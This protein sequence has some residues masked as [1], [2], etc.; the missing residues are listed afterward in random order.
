MS[1]EYIA[2][3]ATPWSLTV[4]YKT[5]LQ[6]SRTTPERFRMSRRALPDSVFPSC[7]QAPGSLPELLFR[8]EPSV[9][10]GK[11]RRSRSA[12]P[13]HPCH[14]QRRRGETSSLPS[15]AELLLPAQSCPC[16]PG[17]AGTQ[18]LGP[19]VNLVS[20]RPILVRLRRR[21]GCAGVIARSG[22]VW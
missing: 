13:A 15:G 2:P 16:Y 9:L 12:L 5:L 20:M 17:G 11:L 8:T 14:P 7:P 1:V 3:W 19:S 18:F 4:I 10:E 22:D 21:C 6:K